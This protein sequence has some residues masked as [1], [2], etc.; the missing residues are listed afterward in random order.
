MVVK[1]DEIVFNSIFSLMEK[2]DDEENQDEKLR[3]CSPTRNLVPLRV[4]NRNSVSFEVELEEKLKASEFK[5]VA[6]LEKNSQLMKDLSKIKEELNHSLK[7][8]DSSKILSNLANQKFN[9]KKGL[10]CRQIKLPYNPHR[11]YVSV[12][13]N[14]LCTHCERNGHLKE[15]CDSLKRKRGS[16]QCWYMDSGCSRHMTGDT[17]NF[18]SL[19]AHQGGGVSFGDG[20]K[21]FIL[22][23][24]KIGRSAAYSIDNVHYVN[25]LKYNLL[26]VS[27]ICYKGNEV[28][29][30]SDWCLVTNRITNK[31]VMSVKRVKNMYVA[32]LDPIKG[33]NLTCLSSQTDN[34]NI[35]YRR[36]GHVSFSL[37]NKLVAGELVPGLPKLKFSNNKVCEACVRGKQMK[38]SSKLKKGVSTTRPLELLHIDR[39]CHN[40]KKRRQDDFF[41]ENGIH[42][43]FSTPRTSQQNGV[44]ERN[45]RTLVDISRTM[46]IDSGLPMNFWAEAINTTCNVTSKCLIRTVIKKTPY[47]FVNDRKPSIAHLK[48]FGC[49]CFVLNN[50][51]DDLGKFDARSDEGVFVGYSSTSKAYIVFN[52]RTLCV[53]EN[54]HVIFD[55]SYEKSKDELNEDIELEEL[56]KGQQEKVIQTPGSKQISKDGKGA[57]LIEEPCPSG[58]AHDGD[59]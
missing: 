36:L 1:D 56:M 30:L 22:G 57:E 39:T 26:S 28:K 51:K 8:S 29:L 4:G 12:S 42:H 16:S 55:E 21:G 48:P 44:V 24:G 3:A 47:E 53:E 10:A 11:K 45:N 35:W 46:L 33:D 52:K 18:L 17:Q 41:A 50:G 20:K 23:I 13:D 49:K 38:L 7:W 32:D 6:S 15:K 9:N 54:M 31:V 19:E 43:K 5:L 27:Q 34:A 40:P 37:L 58:A 25:G 14:L 59:V 2:S